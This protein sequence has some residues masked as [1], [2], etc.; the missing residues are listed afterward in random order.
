MYNL[1]IVDDEKV[2]RELIVQYLEEKLKEKFCVY[3]ADN[4]ESALALMEKMRIDICV[5]D[6]MMP[7][8]NGIE[9]AEKIHNNY[10]NCIVLILSGYEEF[11]YAQKALRYSV[12]EYLLKPFKV[13]ELCEKILF[14][15]KEL[16]SENREETSKNTDDLFEEQERF[17]VNLVYGGFADEEVEIKKAKTLFSFDL[18]TTPCDIISLKAEEYDYF[19]NNKWSYEKDSLALA[20]NNLVYGF[21]RR[22][23]AFFIH[24]ENGLF[25]YI[26]YHNGEAIDYNDLTRKIS[27]IS[28]MTVRLYKE[29]KRF[30][31]IGELLEYRN[32]NI[33]VE[34]IALLFI[35]HLREKNYDEAKKIIENVCEKE[36]VY[37]SFQKV[38]FNAGLSFEIIDGLDSKNLEEKY[39]ELL[40]MIGNGVNTSNIGNINLSLAM[41]NA[42][43]YIHENYSKNISRDDVAKAVFISP[44]YFTKNFKNYVGDN[45]SDYLFKVRMQNAIRLMK[46]R[47]YKVEQIAQMIGYDQKYFYKAFKVY[48]GYSPREY[49]LRVLGLPENTK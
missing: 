36:A 44:T 6:I 49:M 46:K 18:K 1:L 3:S 28:G 31:N 43:K 34:E 35:T 13:S 16:K 22:Q 5:T 10:K 21:L 29:V 17:L 27:A 8:M 47:E 2:T 4:G 14:F 20:F 9:L 40:E 12:K 41:E 38:L 15:E 19:L 23:H 42:K 11:E 26:I 37:S 33:D 30:S 24:S 45:F 32:E 48:T 25:E 7:K 39:D